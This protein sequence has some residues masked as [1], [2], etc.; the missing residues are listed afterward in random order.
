MEAF[1]FLF[2]FPPCI[3]VVADEVWIFFE[4]GIIVCWKHFRM[5]VYIHTAS[6]C[7][8]EQHFKVTKVMTGNKDAWTGANTDVYLCDFWI[9]VGGSIGIVKESHTVH[10]VFTSF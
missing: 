7:L 5:S 8:F 1:K 4:S 10:T 2:L 3:S 6:L 9:S